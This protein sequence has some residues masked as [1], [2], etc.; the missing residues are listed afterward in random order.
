MFGQQPYTSPQLGTS[1]TLW[2]YG[3]SIVALNLA[4]SFVGRFVNAAEF[5]RGGMDL[6]LT[7]LVWTEGIAR[8]P[9]LQQAF[10]SDG[11]IQIDAQGQAWIQQGGRWTAMQGY[12]GYGDSLVQSS[13]LDGV[14]ERSALDGDTDYSYGHLLPAGTSVEQATQAAYTGSGYTS[15]YHAAFTR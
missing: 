13:A 1:W 4:S 14:V 10:G 9:R 6:V 11:Q 2:Q 3:A 5:R 8:M 7:K 12:Q 15:P